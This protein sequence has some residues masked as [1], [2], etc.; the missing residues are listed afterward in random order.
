MRRCFVGCETKAIQLAVF[1]GSL[2]KGFIGLSLLCIAH[3]AVPMGSSSNG[4]RTANGGRSAAKTFLGVRRFKNEVLG[5]FR[6]VSFGNGARLDG[7]DPLVWVLRSELDAL[8]E[9]ARGGHAA[10]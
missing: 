10:S 8:V 4:R 3:V 1:I 6:P 2:S 7:E 9:T 5:L